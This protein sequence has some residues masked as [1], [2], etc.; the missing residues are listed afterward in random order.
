[1]AERCPGCG[2]PNCE[3]VLYQPDCPAC[4]RPPELCTCP[5]LFR[6]EEG[7]DDLAE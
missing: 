5:G 4:L 3:C 2:E 7:D 1:M 6:D